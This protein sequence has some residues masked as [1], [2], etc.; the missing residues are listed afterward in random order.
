MEPMP[1]IIIGLIAALFLGFAVAVSMRKKNGKRQATDYRTIFY[2]GFLWFVMGMSNDMNVFFI[3]GLAYMGMGLANRDKWKKQTPLTKQQMNIV[4]LLVGLLVI[5]ILIVLI[6]GSGR[7]D[8]FGL[9]GWIA[10]QRGINNF[11]ECIAAG[12]PAMESYPRQCNACGQHFVEEIEKT[13]CEIDAD[14]MVFGQDGDCNCGCYKVGSIP[15][16]RI[17]GCFC[18]AP[19]SCVCTDGQCE[20]VFE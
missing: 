20:G 16:Q 4:Y 12:N 1:W 6:T 11:E 8:M 9:R 3:L 5:W 18:A 14:C 17:E 15:V 19:T 10:C 13:D 7:V 2:L